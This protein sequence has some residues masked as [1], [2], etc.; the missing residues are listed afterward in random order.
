M[1]RRRTFWTPLVHVYSNGFPERGRHNLQRACKHS[2]KL[3]H[4]SSPIILGLKVDPEEQA[5][6]RR[7]WTVGG[8]EIERRS[9]VSTTDCSGPQRE[10]LTANYNGVSAYLAALKVFSVRRGRVKQAKASRAR[11]GMGDRPM[12]EA[13]LITTMSRRPTIPDVTV[14]ASLRLCPDC[15][16]TLSPFPRIAT[17]SPTSCLFP[18]LPRF[19]TVYPIFVPRCSDVG[20]F[21]HVGITFAVIKEDRFCLTPDSTQRVVWLIIRSVV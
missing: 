8:T 17:V 12:R 18:S 15:A 9:R 21:K 13:T 7:I 6:E 20:N 1:W 10:N 3:Q 4:R 16:P 2:F 14:S 5:G 11:W 19:L